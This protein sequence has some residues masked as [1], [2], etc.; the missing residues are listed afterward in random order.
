MVVAGGM[1]T[2][3]L[4]TLVRCIF[5]DRE[6]KIIGHSGQTVIGS[7]VMPVV[8]DIWQSMN[9]EELVKN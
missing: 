8:F 4:T 5:G 2:I 6:A 3:I 9:P 7:S 1:I